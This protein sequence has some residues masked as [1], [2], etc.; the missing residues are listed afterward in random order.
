MKLIKKILL[1]LL[2][3][4]L[5]LFIVGCKKDTDIFENR[6]LDVKSTDGN[7]RP[8]DIVVHYKTDKRVLEVGEDLPVIVSFGRTRDYAEPYK[9]SIK[10]VTA[11]LSMRTPTINS[12]F[13]DDYIECLSLKTINDFSRDEYRGTFTS[14]E[15]VVNVI[16]PSKWFDSRSDAIVFTLMVEEEYFSENENII[17]KSTGGAASLYFRIDGNKV[18]LYG[19]SYDFNNDII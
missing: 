9:S 12:V 8:P 13:F 5:S 2:T 16:I 10:S 6:G 4:N 3:M 15:N 11:E 7:S 17:R 19:S 1:F 18:K 14:D